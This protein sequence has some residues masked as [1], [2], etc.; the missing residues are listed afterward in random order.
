M[1]SGFPGVLREL[2][3]QGGAGVQFAGFHDYDPMELKAVLQETG[4]KAAG[5]HD[6]D[7]T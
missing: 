4:L 3:R 6:T 1:P 7:E 2:K 5:L